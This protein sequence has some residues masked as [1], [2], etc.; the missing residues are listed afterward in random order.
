VGITLHEALVHKRARIALIA[1]AD[2]V[3]D[4]ALGGKRGLPLSSR[5]KARPAAPM[6]PP[7]QATFSRV[8][9]KSSVVGLAS[10]SLK[11]LSTRF[12]SN[13][14]WF[15]WQAVPSQILITYFPL[16]FREKSA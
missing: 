2:E 16:G 4:V 5:G 10:L 1:V 8:K 7:G 14:L 3:L 13:W 12:R 15:T 6:Q 9:S 11:R